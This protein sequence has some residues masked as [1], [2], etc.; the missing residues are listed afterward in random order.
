MK[1]KPLIS[2]KTTEFALRILFFTFLAFSVYWSVLL[3][4]FAIMRFADAPTVERGVFILFVFL[5]PYFAA[6]NLKFYFDVL[7]K[8][9][10]T[11]RWTAWF[12]ARHDEMLFAVLLTIALEI[13]ILLVSRGDV[14]ISNAFRPI[15][16]IAS[17]P[18]WFG[19]ILMN[20]V[21]D[22]TD[23][24]FPMLSFVNG[25]GVLVG[26]SFQLMASYYLA[27]FLFWAPHMHRK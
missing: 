19:E 7:A 2:N 27:K 24:Y 23:R 9:T 14:M 12:K 25:L 1:R 10:L 3:A 8:E 22:G 16:V 6:L 26:V 15:F 4:L 11:A 13:L 18:T 17:G 5:L 20:I 21:R